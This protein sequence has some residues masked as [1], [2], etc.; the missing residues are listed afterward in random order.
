MEQLVLSVKWVRKLYSRIF[1]GKEETHVKLFCLLP[2]GVCID[3]YVTI[4]SLDSDQ[5]GQSVCSDLGPF[6]P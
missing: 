5:D 6:V 2:V 4:H 1:K 3:A